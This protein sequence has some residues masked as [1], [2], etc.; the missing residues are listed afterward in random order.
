MLFGECF[1]DLLAL[2][3]LCLILFGG[4]GG[5]GGLGFRVMLTV[6]LRVC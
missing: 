3:V 6:A 2:N 4:R 5:G 1:D